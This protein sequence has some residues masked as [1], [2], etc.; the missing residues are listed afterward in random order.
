MASLA[1]GLQVM[2][3]FTAD[4]P[5]LGVGELA[6][7]LEMDKRRAQRLISTLYELGYLDQ[8]PESR[9]YRPGVAVL[10]LGYAALQSLDVRQIARPH[11]RVLVERFGQSV[12]LAV[13]D[14]TDV[15]LVECLRGERYRLGLRVH[16]GERL[17]L[18]LSSLGKAIMSR[19]PAAEV[20]GLAERIDFGR[21]TEHSVG[22]S[23]E[24]LEQVARA[25]EHGYA[26]MEQETTLGVRSVSV[27]L[28]AGDGH[29]VAAVNVAMPTPL[30]SMAE[31]EETVA[32]VLVATG[33][34]ISA[35]LASGDRA[36]WEPPGTPPAAS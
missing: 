3:A 14:R 29:P 17:P 8:D 7:V 21:R 12:N 2:A 24:L 26:V 15:M 11:L 4:R 10:T 19:L 16:V 30:M 1:A 33:A 32:P 5:E 23:S 25:R 18:H 34:R 35:L 9:R 20:T 13:R 27:P 22:S 36:H 6:R 28:L 31:M